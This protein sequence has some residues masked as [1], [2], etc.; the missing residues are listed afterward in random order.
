MKAI[1]NENAR[2]TFFSLYLRILMYSR[3]RDNVLPKFHLQDFA[4]SLNH[5]R[6]KLEFFQ[7]DPLKTIVRVNRSK[8][9]GITLFELLIGH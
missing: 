2:Y 5:L 1:T 9:S 7:P 4:V 8:T 6:D 3:L